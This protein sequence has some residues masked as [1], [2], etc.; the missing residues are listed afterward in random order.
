MEKKIEF[1]NENISFGYTESREMTTKYDLHCHNFYEIYFFVEGD[2]DYLV[3]GTYYKPEPG[4]LLLF[5]PNAFHGVKI[6][7]RAPYKRYT[8]HFDQNLLLPERRSFLMRA[9]PE[10]N[11][12]SWGT[13]YYRKEDTEK[14]D[15]QVYLSALRECAEMDEAR[16]EQMI[17]LCV[18]AVLSRILLMREAGKEMAVREQ[19]DTI[20][21]IL[22]YLNSHLQEQVTLDELAEKFF[23]SKHHLNKV[24]RKRTGTTVMDYL[25]R[26]R[27]SSA[28][29]ML[30][31]GYNAKEAA[32]QSGFGEYS[33]FY[34]AYVRVTGHEPSRDRGANHFAAEHE[35]EPP[36]DMLLTVRTT[37]VEPVSPGE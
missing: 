5:A 16:R 35:G 10:G 8:L 31:L 18:E 21:E 37:A 7:S 6:N 32:V 3:E 14:Y 34:R 30:F 36:R 4:S 33:S 15:L 27:V 29:Q 20:T 28:Q 9:L 26:K 19:K 13:I 2:V 22:Y 11:K 23:I 17:P 12:E 24:F 25:Q 1:W